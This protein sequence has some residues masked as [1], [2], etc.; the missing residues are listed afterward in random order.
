MSNTF[1]LGL[2]GQV[3]DTVRKDVDPRL[4]AQ[5]LDMLI[6]IASQPGASQ[7]VLS[8]QVGITGAAISRSVEKLVKLGLVTRYEDPQDRRT[9]RSNLT[10]KG[11]RV[12]GNIDKVVQKRLKSAGFT[13]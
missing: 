6:R 4:E 2:I 10:A 11:E 3:I 8:E 1:T 7:T 9:K 13:R 12:I 5:T